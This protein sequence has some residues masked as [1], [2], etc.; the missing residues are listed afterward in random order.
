MVLGVTGGIAAVET[1]RLARALRRE[2][3]DLLVIMTPSAQRIITPLAVRWASQAEVIT[4]WDGDLTALNNADA[5]LIAPAT[6]DAMA[7]HVHGLQ[8]GPLMMA[9]SVARSRNTPILFAPSMHLDLAKDPV[10]EELVAA[11]RAQGAHVAWGPMEEGKRK[12]PSVERLVAQ[13]AHLVNRKQPNR[14]SVVVTL[15]AT[16][17]SIDDVRHVQNTSSGATGWSIADHLYKHGHDVTCV[18]GVT[19]TAAPEWL[20]LVLDC[21]TPEAMLRE[22]RALA[23]DPIEAWVHAA[24]VLDYVV[25]NPAEGKLASQQGTLTLPLVES[26]KHIMELKDACSTAVRIGFKLESGVKQN[27]LIHRAFAQIQKAGM[28]AVVANRL[29]DLGVE[30]K[31]RGYLV[32][33]QGAHFV[34]ESTRDLNDAM[35]TLI[36]RG[37]ED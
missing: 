10:T 30:G 17:S 22:C 19:T 34:L 21:P 29:E 18:A 6:R 28:S 35:L 8:H 12:T 24:A 13:T 7:S 3:A 27:D 33:R 25:E 20:P 31:P 15:G 26:A 9:L 16:R 5:V 23:N 14:R 11:V 32:D 4:D 36:E 2:G 1:V 37:K